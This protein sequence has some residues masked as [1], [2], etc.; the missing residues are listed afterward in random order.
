[1]L[2]KAIANY[3]MNHAWLETQKIRANQARYRETGFNKESPSKYLI[4][5]LDLIGLV[6]NYTDTET[7]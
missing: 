7:I 6:Y 1:M 2:K 3:W 4:R 5:K